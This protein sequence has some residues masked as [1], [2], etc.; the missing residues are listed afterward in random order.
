MESCIDWEK[1]RV[2]DILVIRDDFTIVDIFL[3]FEAYLNVE[4]VIQGETY[5]IVQRLFLLVE[6]LEIF[7]DE[8]I[9][10]R[11]TPIWMFDFL[12]VLVV[13]WHNSMLQ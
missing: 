4:D 7:H 12:V 5:G 8:C 6:E 11:P 13:F 2:V 1:Y 9:G 3:L 10:G